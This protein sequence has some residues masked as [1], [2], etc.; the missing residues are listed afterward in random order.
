MKNINKNS[1]DVEKDI[2][3]WIKEKIEELKNTLLKI[4]AKA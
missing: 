4:Y 3:A 1:F 2:Q